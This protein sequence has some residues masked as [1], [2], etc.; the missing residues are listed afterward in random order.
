MDRHGDACYGG[1]DPAPGP[2]YEYELQE[3]PI[4][5][6]S[7]MSP[8]A[9]ASVPNPSRGETDPAAMHRQPALHT[10]NTNRLLFASTIQ[11]LRRRSI[12]SALRSFE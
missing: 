8:E 7:T 3:R 6:G 5:D 9:E 4:L 11:W 2:P 1:E 12:S 10:T